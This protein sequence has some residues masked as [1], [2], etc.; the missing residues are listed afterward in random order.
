MQAALSLVAGQQLL[1]PRLIDGNLASFQ[2][3]D[4][5]RID[6]H[7]YDVVAAFREARGRYQTHITGSYDC[8]LHSAHPK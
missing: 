7:A 8:Y 2:G 3:R 1:Q 4:F 6:V 5:E